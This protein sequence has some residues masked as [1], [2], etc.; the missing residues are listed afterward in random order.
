MYVIGLTGNIATGKSTVAAMLARLG[1][2]TIDADEVAHQVM[3]TDETVRHRIVQRFSPD[4]LDAEGQIDRSALGAIV[5]SDA[6]A[7]C[8]LE[9]IV[10]PAV[11]DRIKER[12]ERCDADV[13]V[14][15][16]IKL[17]EAK[18]H[19][20]C[21]S[22]WVVTSPREVQLERLMEKRGL[23][24]EEA[25]RRID[26]QPPAEEKVTRADCVID[27]SGSLAQ[28]WRQV[29][30][31]WD[32]VPCTKRVPVNK[33]CAG[34]E[35]E[36]GRESFQGRLKCFF[37]EHPR[38]SSWAVLSVGMIIL[39]VLMA[40]GTLSVGQLLRLAVACIALAGAC[41]WIISWE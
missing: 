29:R 41:A 14:V 34:F 26:A 6:Q 13:A 22:V 23:T 2:Y 35:V 18:V 28:T 39:L 40:P 36:R 12:L 8:D 31:A 5:F 3:R 25:Q 15:E 7:L 27:N 19:T 10:H 9:E 37:R 21:D 32:A 4:I 38:L 20:Y 11:L 17:L 1:A 30:E 24:A 33:P 16:A